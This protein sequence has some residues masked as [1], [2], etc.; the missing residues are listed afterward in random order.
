MAVR[1]LLAAFRV[2]AWRRAVEASTRPATDLTGT[3]FRHPRDVL[4]N[5]YL[6]KAQKR[7]VLAY[8]ASD[9]HA[10]PDHPALRRLDNGSTVV[11]DEI[12]DALKHLDGIDMAGDKSPRRGPDAAGKGPAED[13]R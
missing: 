5:I 1:D 8:W 9:I 2:R 7:Q 6:G 12:L 3:S 11:I 4:A 13:G 10:V